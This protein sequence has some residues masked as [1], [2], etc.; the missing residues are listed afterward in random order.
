MSKILFVY[1]NKE[2]YPIIPLGISVLSGI[3]KNNNHEVDLFDITFM[4][5]ERLD[6][7]A[8]EKTNLVKKVDVQKYWGT[9]DNLDINEELKKKILVFKPDLIAF[10]IVENNYSIAKKLLK[11]S[12]E[13]LNVL[14][15]V[16]GIFPTIAA[17]FFV[18]D[19]NVDIIC[20]GE[21]EYA[22]LELANRIDQNKDISDI[23][24]LIVKTSKGL[25]K[26]SFSK[27]Y[28]W[29]PP[30]FQDWD[31]FDKRHLKKPFIGKMWQTGFFEISRGCPFQCTYCA[32]HM[33]QKVFKSLGRYRRNKPIE[34][35][36]REIEYM[37]EKYSLELIFFNDENFMMMDFDRFKSFCENFKK[38]INLPFFIQT[39][40]DTL[41][42]E[43]RIKMLKEANCI[44]VGIGV[45]SGSVKIRE[46]ILNKTV[47]EDV[48]LKAFKN[49]NKYKIRTTAYV[50]IGLPFETEKDI[51][52]TADFCKKLNTES[53]ALSIFAPYHGTKLRNICIENG[54][55]EDSYCDDISV[56]Y[57]SILNMPQINKKNLEI[58]ITNSMT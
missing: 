11:L 21:G 25:I 39:R 58:Y 31:I 48:Y 19:E 3:L 46:K 2:G 17:N 38:R 50:M 41:L 6:H 42:Q 55:I 18:K 14:T 35:G 43:E 1:P 44:T 33:Y 5:P 29:E 28:D 40:A 56:N 22:M 45:E 23:K 7:N 51:L 27:F 24:N 16:G 32:N 57:S 9:G 26:N 13:T 10:S 4:M 49:C 15:I 53:I 8:R 34:Y 52:L 47:S 12:K 20:V 37:K 36:I 54:F 30:V